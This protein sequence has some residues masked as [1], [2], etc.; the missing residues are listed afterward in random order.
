MQAKFMLGKLYT[1]SFVKLFA[2]EILSTCYP[3]NGLYLKIRASEI[4]I[5]E[6]R[7]SKGPPVKAIS[8]KSSFNLFSNTP[9]FFEHN[10][11]KWCMSGHNLIEKLFF[12]LMLDVLSYSLPTALKLAFMFIIS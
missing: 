3:R 5:S 1:S 12:W 7:A 4:L 11:L 6:I 9:L 10:F 2:S 8:E